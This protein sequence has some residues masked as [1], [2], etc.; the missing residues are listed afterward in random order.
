MYKRQ[1][2]SS[3]IHNILHLHPIHNYR[4]NNL[5]L[6]KLIMN[7]ITNPFCRLLLSKS[8]YE[9][10]H[11]NTAQKSFELYSQHILFFLVNDYFLTIF[12]E[13]CQ[14]CLLPVSYTHL[15]VYKRQAV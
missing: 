11:E 7:S 9:R 5:S 13:N 1:C 12:S 2:L 4:Y 14:F 8:M 10:E 15:D 6:D 3:G